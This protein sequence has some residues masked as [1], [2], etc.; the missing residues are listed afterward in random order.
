MTSV[1]ARRHR[2]RE[3]DVI[4]VLPPEQVTELDAGKWEAI[5]RSFEDVGDVHVIMSNRSGVMEAFGRF[6]NFSRMGPYF[7]VL[8]KSLDMHLLPDTFARIFSVEKPS[9]M[10]GKPT[11]S[12]QFFNIDGD[13]AFKVFFSFGKAAP[14]DERRT[15]WE[16]MRERFQA[17]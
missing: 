14:T 15:M 3:I 11:L 9:H 1:L 16:R 17:G 6:G 10:D 7:N 5:L 12:I 2:L 4:G 8:T 13:A